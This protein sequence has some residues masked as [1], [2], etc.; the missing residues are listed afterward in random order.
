[1][2]Q[3]EIDETIE[4]ISKKYEENV[5]RAL[6]LMVRKKAKMI[7]KFEIE[8]MPKSLRDCTVEE[9]IMIIKNAIQQGTLKF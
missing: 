6:R 9:Y 7:E 3:S 4:Y 8:E 1:M 2:N 5:P